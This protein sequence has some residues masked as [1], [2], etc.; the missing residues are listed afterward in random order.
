LWQSFAVAYRLSTIYRVAIAFM[1]PSQAPSTPAPNPTTVGLSVL[2]APVPPSP[3]AAAGAAGEPQLSL[4]RMQISTALPASGSDYLDVLTVLEPPLMLQGGVAISLSGQGLAPPP[5][6]APLVLV[7]STA[8]G[9]SSW[10]ITG[11]QTAPPADTAMTLTPPSTYAI[12]GAA[13]PPASTPP[14]GVYLLAVGNPGSLGTAVPVVIAPV[15]TNVASPAILHLSGGSYSF[16]GAGFLPG[17]TQLYVNGALL[18]P[19]T[20][21]ISSAGTSVSFTL[22]ASMPH[23]TWPLRVRIEGIDAPA[24]W[25]VAA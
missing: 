4:P 22:P 18:D 8:D 16:T 5:P 7:L 6:A 3:P 25:Q 15:F 21:N 19:S 24:T 13:A 23:G 12:G 2:Q 11:W 20:V 10:T 1:T 17:A 9:A 14:P